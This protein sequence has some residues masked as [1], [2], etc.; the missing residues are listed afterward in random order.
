MKTPFTVLPIIC[1]LIFSCSKSTTST[2]LKNDVSD[3]GFNGKVKSVKSEV[4]NLIPEKDTFRIGEKINGISFDQKF[5]VG[6]QSFW[7]SCFFKRISR[8]W[9]S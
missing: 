6:I 8:R 9:K 5:V 1:F 2:N 7:E 4:F 3:Y